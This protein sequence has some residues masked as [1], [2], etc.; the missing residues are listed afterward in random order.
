[1]YTNRNTEYL[2][3]GAA[4]TKTTSDFPTTLN[5]GEIGIF[6]PEGVRMTEFTADTETRFMIATKLAD[7]TFVTTP[8]IKKAEIVSAKRLVYTAATQQLDYIGYTG[9][10][11]SIDVVNSEYYS[12]YIHLQEG[13][14]SSSDGIKIKHAFYNSDSAATQAEIAIGI[15][16][17]LIANFSREAEEWVTFKA[18]C[19]EAVTSTNDFDNEIVWAK[20]SKTILATTNTQY[21]G[22]SSLAVGDFIRLQTSEAVTTTT[23]DIY[24]VKSISGLVITVDRPIQIT[25][26]SS[27]GNDGTGS[28]VLT[29]A[30]GAAANWGI[31]LTGQALEFA[32]GKFG[33]SVARW[34]VKLRGADTD[35]GWGSTTFTNSTAATEGSGVINQLKE[36]EWFLWGNEGEVYRESFSETFAART[37]ISSA[38]GG[39]GYDLIRLVIEAENNVSLTKTVSPYVITLAL[40]A[41][42]PNYAIEG[43][44]DDITDVLEELAFGSVNDNLAIT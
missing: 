19:N 38:V 29:A 36:L 31:A 14:R 24:R 13:V 15:T 22:G 18:I 44:A 12:V 30:E 5:T 1:M 28:E 11:G 32:T 6:T 16:G 10:T 25:Y 21:G 23:S 8:A 17:S 20:G 34:E 43:T 2:H 3:V 39:G 35:E 7:G 40:P 41:T 26:Y 27:P 9:S 33:Y 37:N 42:A 4:A